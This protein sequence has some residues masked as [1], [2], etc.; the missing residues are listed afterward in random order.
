MMA[1]VR[2]FRCAGSCMCVFVPVFQ[3]TIHDLSKSGAALRTGHQG[4]R[5]GSPSGSEQTTAVFVN[6]FMQ[7][8]FAMLIEWSLKM[9]VWEVNE[10]VKL[11]SGLLTLVNS[12]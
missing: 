12:L 9:Y 3:L 1:W 10:C 11:S 7:V 2:V 8:P 5:Q 4:E 6:N